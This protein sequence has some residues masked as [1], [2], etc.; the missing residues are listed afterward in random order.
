MTDQ[1][2]PL[3]QAFTTACAGSGHAVCQAP[4]TC[5]RMAAESETL[6]RTDRQSAGYD[7]RL[8]A[9]TRRRQLPDHSWKTSELVTRVEE[10]LHSQPNLDGPFR[11]ISITTGLARLGERGLSPDWLV[12]THIGPSLIRRIVLAATSVWHEI[13]RGEMDRSQVPELH[14]WLDGV[15]IDAPKDYDPDRDRSRLITSSLAGATFERGSRWVK[16]AS[17]SDIAAWRLTDYTCSPPELEDMALPGGRT[18]TRWLYERITRTY[19]AEWS[20][21]SWAWEAAY[22]EHPTDVARRAGVGLPILEERVCT[23]SQLTRA[24]SAYVLEDLG[25]ILPGMSRNEFVELV[26]HHL[27]SGH[28][29]DARALSEAA[30]GARPGDDSVRSIFAF[31]WLP[32]DPRRSREIIAATR[33]NRTMSNAVRHV[34]VASSYLAEDDADSAIS[35]VRLLKESS[36]G[37]GDSAWLWDPRTLA[38]QPRVTFIA[39]SQWAILAE[40]QLRS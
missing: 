33:E 26:A 25:E 7:A 13:H 10:L 23:Q 19:H 27:E 28:H 38:S 29:A 16:E 2:Y 30:L 14:G 24:A 35:A 31:C 6:E 17:M 34:N 5:E 18:A 37:T 21:E 11:T 3:I 39:P 4:Q 40:D 22:I 36:D 20:P 1:L 8:L 9:I 12:R 32:I 15:D